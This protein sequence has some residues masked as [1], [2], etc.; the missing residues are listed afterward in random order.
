M[1]LSYA[2]SQ[3][4]FASCFFCGQAGP[5]TVMDLNVKP[6]SVEPY[7]Q[8]ETLLTFK[9]TLIVKESNARGLHYTL[10]QALEIP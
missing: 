6:R 4:S 7:R 10:D 8:K 9:G 2:L 5:E 1:G 3:T